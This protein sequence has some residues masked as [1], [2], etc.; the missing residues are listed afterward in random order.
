MTTTYS[1]YIKYCSMFLK[2][3]ISHIGSPPS[4]IN[5]DGDILQNMEYFSIYYHSMSEYGMHVLVAKHMKPHS[6]Y[7]MWFDMFGHKDT[8]TS[9]HL[10]ALTRRE[11]RQKRI[12]FSRSIMLSIRGCHDVI[13]RDEAPDLLVCIPDP[14][15]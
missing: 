15:A 10:F 5:F 12:R 2:N 11:L 1:F 9:L 3:L 8:H 7:T 14:V 13:Q 6:I 4:G